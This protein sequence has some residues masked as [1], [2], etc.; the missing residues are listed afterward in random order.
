MADGIAQSLKDLPDEPLLASALAGEPLEQA[1]DAYLSWWRPDL[2]E[3]K[4]ALV[5]AEGD[6]GEPLY[7]AGSLDLFTVLLALAESQQVISLD[8]YHRMRVRQQ[9]RPGQRIIT[10]GRR[11]GQV[12]GVTSNQDFHSFSV[13]VW[14]L[15][16]ETLFPDGARIGDWRNFA[17]VDVYGR[18][19]P[20]CGTGRVAFE[21]TP[22]QLSFLQSRGMETLT[23]P[24]EFEHFVHPQ[25]YKAAFGRRYAV[26]KALAELVPKERDYWTSVEKRVGAALLSKGLSIDDIVRSR[27]S[28]GI[29]GLHESDEEKGVSE[30][31]LSLSVPGLVA[32]V[33]MPVT[34]VPYTWYGLSADGEKR[35]LPPDMERLSAGELEDLSWYIHD[36]KSELSYTL[37]PRVRAPLRAV[38]LALYLKL[39]EGRDPTAIS[40]AELADIEDGISAL[41]AGAGWPV[42]PAEDALLRRT[43][44]RRMDFGNGYAM[45]YWLRHKATKVLESELSGDVT[46]CVVRCE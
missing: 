40:E 37:G 12:R 28:H 7:R 11:H 14:D 13:R 33:S 19:R 15:S 18:P 35:E 43:K 10:P 42:P 41:A 9:E 2:T 20:G 31:V 8:D 38:E 3:R 29:A 39:I 46:G 16:V 30:P 25:L 45:N 21:A 32:E 23:A 22:E 6:G 44:C 36:R 5:F 26:G 34:A 17:L 4:P 1:I 24:V 27:K